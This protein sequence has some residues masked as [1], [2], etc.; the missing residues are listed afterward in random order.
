[1]KQ[2][3]NHVGL[4]QQNNQTEEKNTS[5]HFL[6]PGSWPTVQFLS[7]LSHSSCT[8]KAKDELAHICTAVQT[9]QQT[10]L[11]LYPFS[12]FNVRHILQGTYNVNGQFSLSLSLS[13]ETKNISKIIPLPRTLHVVLIFPPLIPGC[14]MISLQTRQ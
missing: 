4:K 8:Y 1:M 11:F 7:Q 2:L 5:T 10:L 3:L 6:T 9:Q 13:K 14:P 12:P